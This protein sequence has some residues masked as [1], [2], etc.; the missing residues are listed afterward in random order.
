MRTLL[1]VLLRLI[2]GMLSKT[3]KLFKTSLFTLAVGCSIHS[4][5]YEIEANQKDI[6]TDVCLKNRRV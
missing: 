6:E 5:A 2:A 4:N 3:Q 1:F